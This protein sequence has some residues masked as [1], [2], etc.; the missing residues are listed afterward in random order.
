[1]ATAFPRTLMPQSSSWPKAPGGLASWSVGGVG[2]TRDVSQ[3]G[4]SWTE[5]WPPLLGSDAATQKFLAQVAGYYAAGTVLTLQHQSR[6]T[7][8]GVGTGTPL[9]KDANQTG[10]SLIT[11]GWTASQTGILKAG[12]LIT[13]ASI[14]WVFEVTADC[15][16]DGATPSVATI[17]ISPGILAGASPA[18]NAAIV[19]T[20]AAVFTVVIESEPNWPTC[21]PDHWY[22]G[23]K[24]TFREVGSLS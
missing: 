20:A 21:G 3:K 17:P 15:N 6:K 23:F 10:K 2:Q 18:D 13:L 8:L 22:V 11:D 9:V 7:T 24:I 1:V 16:S 12:D 4:R 14:P 19:V 5:E